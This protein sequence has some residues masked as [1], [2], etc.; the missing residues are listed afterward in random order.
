MTTFHILA[1][2]LCLSVTAQ[3]MTETQK[4]ALTICLES[5]TQG[6]T[7][8]EL[9]ASSIFN[10]AESITAESLVAVCLK[11][12]AYSC[13]N[14]RKPS[15]HLVREI[16]VTKRGRMMW[17][18]AMNTAGEMA[19]G[20]YKPVISAQFYITKKLYYSARRPVWTNGLN[21]VCQYKDHVFLKEGE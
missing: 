5:S 17:E 4:I 10:R 8:R 13:W 14:N 15:I 18:S 16:C 11:P 9:V 6:W 20:T 3:A 1:L 7:G 21:V 2:T 19:R 12:K